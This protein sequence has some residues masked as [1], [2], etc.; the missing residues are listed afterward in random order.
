[1]AAPRVLTRLIAGLRAVTAC[2]PQVGL[3]LLPLDDRRLF[4]TASLARAALELG[5]VTDSVL[6]IDP[7]RGVSKYRVQLKALM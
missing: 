4:I 6:G 1:M 7:L 5:D 2:C 3:Q